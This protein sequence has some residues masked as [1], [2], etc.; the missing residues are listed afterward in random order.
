MA[1]PAGELG[2][3]LGGEAVV[4]ERARGL[5]RSKR[6]LG[7]RSVKAE[8]CTAWTGSPSSVNMAA[9]ANSGPSARPP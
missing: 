1:E 5:A 9:W 7:S 4:V 6:A 3:V 2:E 8:R